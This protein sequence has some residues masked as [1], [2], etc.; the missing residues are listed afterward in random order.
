MIKK[1]V[2]EVVYAVFAFPVHY[3]IKIL[4]ELGFFWLKII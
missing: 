2:F 4:F 3:A 1:C